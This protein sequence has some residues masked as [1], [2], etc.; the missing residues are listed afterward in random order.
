MTI[1]VE[2]VLIETTRLKE[3][4]EFYRNGFGFAEPDT[5]EADQVGF[6]I[7]EV[8]FGLEQVDEEVAASRRMSL[9]FKVADARA[10]YERLLSLGATSKDIPE[11]VDD[12]VVAAVYDPD[13]NALGLMSDRPDS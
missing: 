4:A 8:Y 11:S 2:A 3:L 9:W 7:G 10:V 12:E 5:L 13:G 6:Q 1:G